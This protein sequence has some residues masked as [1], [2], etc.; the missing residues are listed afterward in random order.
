MKP[1]QDPIRLL[2][3]EFSKDAVDS[4]I[5]DTCVVFGNRVRL[6]LTTKTAWKPLGQ[7]KIYSVGDLF[8]FLDNKRQ[9]KSVAEYMKT[10]RDLK[11]KVPLQLISKEHMQD[12]EE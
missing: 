7:G 3:R 5:E 10:L 9:R 12:I 6:E 4:R 8:I 2:R 11:A 1:H